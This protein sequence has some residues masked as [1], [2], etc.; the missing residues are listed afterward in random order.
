MGGTTSI[1]KR[2]AYGLGEI[3]ASIFANNLNRRLANNLA[4]N[5]LN[6]I[7]AISI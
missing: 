6:K 1:T 7:C 5:T 2:Q 3:L 4:K